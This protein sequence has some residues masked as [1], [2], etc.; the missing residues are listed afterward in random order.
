[1]TGLADRLLFSVRLPPASTHPA[2]TRGIGGMP[3]APAANNA[4][5]GDRREGNGLWGMLQVREH[6]FGVCAGKP[7]QAR[8]IASPV[9]M[10]AVPIRCV[11]ECGAVARD[12]KR[13]DRLR[14]WKISWRKHTPPTTDPRC[15]TGCPGT[16]SRTRWPAYARTASANYRWRSCVAARIQVVGARIFIHKSAGRYIWE[17]GASSAFRLG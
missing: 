16:P 8:V 9:H 12:S 2:S 13:P 5:Q 1:M 15:F 7:T 6:P 10:G 11:R 3:D 17:Q 14:S 4:E